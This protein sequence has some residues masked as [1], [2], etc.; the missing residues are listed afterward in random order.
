MYRVGIISS[1]SVFNSIGDG[2]KDGMAELGYV[3]GENIVY[4]FQQGTDDPATLTPV[5]E[6]FV[7]DEADLI[8]AYPTGASV[9]AKAGTEGTDIPVVF[10]F[11]ALEGAGLPTTVRLRR[12][13]SIEA[14]CG[15]LRQRQIG[16]A[17][18]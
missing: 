5:V 4:D 12:G 13:A 9:A 11:A 16:I 17:T 1:F 7:A 6:Q 2:F 10:S 14:G 15:Q 3:E 18:E 8:F